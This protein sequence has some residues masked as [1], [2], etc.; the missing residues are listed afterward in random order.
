MKLKYRKKWK[1]K[2]CAEWIYN[3]S[4]KF[5]H[6]VHTG[7]N[8]KWMDWRVCTVASV[9]YTCNRGTYVHQRRIRVYNGAC[10]ARNES[11]ASCAEDKSRESRRE[12]DTRYTPPIC[13]PW[14]T[15]TIGVHIAPRRATYGHCARD[16]CLRSND[17]SYTTAGVAGLYTIYNTHTSAYFHSSLVALNFAL[18]RARVILSCDACVW[19][20]RVENR[21][22]WK[23]WASRRGWIPILPLCAWSHQQKKKKEIRLLTRGRLIY[24]INLL[25]QGKIAS[26]P[27]ARRNKSI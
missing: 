18:T 14:R 2:Q 22:P 13:P 25:S 26:S 12:A 6:L 16:A 5:A 24:V 1:C 15:H 9:Y 8:Y 23:K 27:S 17:D 3:A 19:H 11:V 4:L 21:C 7:K 20:T 10:S